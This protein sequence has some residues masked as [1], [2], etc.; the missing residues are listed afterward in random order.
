MSP[1]RLF[2][3]TK[4]FG[5]RTSSLSFYCYHQYHLYPISTTHNPFGLLGVGG[6]T[7]SVKGQNLHVAT[8]T[9][10]DK[11][12]IIKEHLLIYGRTFVVEN[13]IQPEFFW[14]AP[15]VDEERPDNVFASAVSPCSMPDKCPNHP[16][17]D[18]KALQAVVQQSGP[19]NLELQWLHGIKDIFSATA[20]FAALAGAMSPLVDRASHTAA[21][22]L[23]VVGVVSAIIAMV[24]L[25]YER[26]IR[27]YERFIVNSGRPTVTHYESVYSRW[28]RGVE[29][30][31]ED[32]EDKEGL[33]R[34]YLYDHVTPA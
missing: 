33:I 2:R 15:L 22:C 28:N 12:S 29:D 21:L 3:L 25:L 11:V 24:G 5:S 30:E 8:G 32:E 16:E 9:I 19:S 27:A 1:S 17:R 4:T 20:A 18:S 7:Y 23:A 34:R 26:F 13:M 10:V 6:H 31:E 14:L